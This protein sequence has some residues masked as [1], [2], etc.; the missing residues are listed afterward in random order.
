MSGLV[1]VSS[2]RSG[3]AF[4]ALVGASLA[5]G[6]LAAGALSAGAHIGGS[7]GYASILISG[8]TVRYSLTLSPSA[9]PA[10][11]AEDLILARTGRPESRERVLGYIRQKVSLT[12]PG[13]HCEPVQG[14]VEP[15][16]AEVESATLVMDFACTAPIRSLLIHDDLF[17]VL[18]S[19]HH[20]LARI[21]APGITREFVFATESREASVTLE[22][23]ADTRGIG[24]FFLLGVHHILTGYDHLLFLLALLLRGGTLLSLLKIVTAFTVAHSITLALA[25]FGLVALPD[26][27][28]ESVIAASIIWVAVENVVSTRP[29][30]LRWL[31]SF[32]FG[33]VHGFGFSGALGP[34]QL[35]P[36][37]LAWA[38]LTFNLGVE[39]GQAAVIMALLPFLVWLKHRQWEPRIVRVA[40]MALAAAGVV[41]LIERV[42][43]A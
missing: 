19:D 43:W 10:P 13:N 9:V 42:F 23:A 28:V 17:D 1:S 39:T 20:T 12:E 36:G 33:L 3:G 24:S 31:V 4:R 34:L 8:N 41:W 32:V 40:S 21:E 37:R 7:T 22:G 2:T 11:V 5:V 25:V 15:A 30:R 35:P 27:L 29:P 26:R 16:R 18:G 14:L 6:A 38:L